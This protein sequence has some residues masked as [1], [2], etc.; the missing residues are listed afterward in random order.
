MILPALFLAMLAAP[1]QAVTSSDVPAANPSAAQANIATARVDSEAASLSRFRDESMAS[2]SL[3]NLG[4]D[5]PLGARFDSGSGSHRPVALQAG[6]PG[7]PQVV[8][9]ATRSRV[10][11]HFARRPIFSRLAAERSQLYLGRSLL[12]NEQ[13]TSLPRSEP[14]FSVVWIGRGVSVFSLCSQRCQKNTEYQRNLVPFPDTSPWGRRP[15][16]RRA[17]PPGPACAPL[18]IP[19]EPRCY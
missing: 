5:T 4:P 3:S 17:P 7:R 14:A 13:L 18:S 15:R 16:L 1:Q 6:L 11:K 19:N 2:N 8:D 12:P 10:F 9:S